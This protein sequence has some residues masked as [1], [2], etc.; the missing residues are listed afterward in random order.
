[1]S[2]ELARRAMKKVADSGVGSLSSEELDALI[3][4]AAMAS[5]QPGSAATATLLK[6]A[7]EHERDGR[8]ER[9]L[10]RTVGGFGVLGLLVAFFGWLLWGAK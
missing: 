6:A 2:T 7:L 8:K 5:R 10:A 1:M 9:A 4:L 3:D